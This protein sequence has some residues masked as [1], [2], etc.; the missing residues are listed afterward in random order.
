MILSKDTRKVIDI[1]L[2]YDEDLPNR[3][4]SVRFLETKIKAPMLVYDGV[5]S[6]EDVKPS[7]PV[8]T[9]PE[10]VYAFGERTLKYTS[11]NMKG[12]DVKELQKRLNARGFDCGTADGIFDSK[13]EHGVIAFQTAAGIEVDGKFG[14]ESF[15]ALSVYS[16]T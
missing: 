16:T 1:L 12:E 11:P 15:A 7:E 8:V 3:F 9:E 10:K 5:T 14:K 4:Y 2:T 13:T 6:V